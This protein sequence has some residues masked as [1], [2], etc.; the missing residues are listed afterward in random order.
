[1]AQLYWPFDPSLINYGFGNAP[2]YGGFHN[3]I[4]F[5]V[6]QGTELKATISGTIRNNDAGAVD[7]AGV[8]ITADD[9]RKVRMWHVSRFLVPNGS[10]V[11]AGQVVAL[12]GGARGSWGAGNATGPHLHWGVMVGGQWVDPAGQSPIMFGQAP[13]P[14]PAPSG[15]VTAL[16][17]AVIRGEYGNG[18]ARKAALGSRYDEV[19]AEVN[20]ILNGGGAP[21][22]AVD[23]NAL[24]DAVMRGDYGN[25]E[26]RRQALGGNYDA[27]Q[28]EV[29]RR[30]YG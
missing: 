1:M 5:A 28:A 8:D 24:A 26:A 23:I 21:A 16:A 12:S 27:V 13:T 7:G 19:Q 15:D 4:D 10:R 18:D 11:E 3:G 30:I 29:N 14:A 17:E 20:R 2:G 9:G 22:P 6:G 25:G